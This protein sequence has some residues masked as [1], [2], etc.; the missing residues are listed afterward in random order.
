[1]YVDPI[2]PQTFEDANQIPCENSPQ[3]IIAPDP[4]TDQN[5]QI[6]I[7]QLIRKDPPL[8]FGP[9]QVQTAD[10]PNTASAQD[11]GVYYQNNSNILGVVFCSLNILKKHT[12][13]L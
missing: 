9:T 3:H 11:A 6:L 10:S 5:W 13:S 8:L 12:T 2:T 1:M 7:P 4:D